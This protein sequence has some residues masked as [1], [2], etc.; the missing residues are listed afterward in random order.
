MKEAVKEK[1]NPPRPEVVE[2]VIGLDDIKNMVPS[3][4]REK[5]REIL[6]DGFDSSVEETTGGH[7]LLKIVV[8]EE[9][10]CR[11][12][13]EKRMSKRDLRCGLVRR[14]SDLSDVEKWCELFKAN[15]QK[16]HP[17]FRK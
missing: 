12:G 16:T 1:L 11:I 17:N 13:D 2:P 14:T 6:G 5:I 4:W 15:I 9:W 3:K 8:P 7:F 10:D